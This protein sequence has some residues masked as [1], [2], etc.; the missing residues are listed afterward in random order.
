MHIERYQAMLEEFS[1][2]LPKSKFKIIKQL[3][4][5]ND[6]LTNIIY[7]KHYMVHTNWAARRLAVNKP[8][9]HI[10]ISSIL[11]F[12]SMLSA[13]IPTTY[14]EYKQVEPIF[15]TPSLTC[16]KEDMT[17]LTFESN[18]I[19]SISSLHVVEHVGMGRYGDIL[20][21]F[22]DDKV[23]KE[24]IRV[25]KPNGKI[26]F[27]VPVSD[28]PCIIFNAHRIYSKQMI[29]DMFEGCKLEEF[30]FIPMK[31]D[32][33]IIENATEEDMKGEDYGCGCFIFTKQ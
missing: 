24:L 14:C 30:S 17:K 12:V 20:D 3:P 13:F 16:K 7:D 1:K 33:L 29:V 10:D 22:G 32:T 6:D 2:E 31:K 4:L 26:Y 21:F 28:E 9:K 19:E 8:E 5:L 18:S 15:N 23:I 27:V 25:T 11:Y